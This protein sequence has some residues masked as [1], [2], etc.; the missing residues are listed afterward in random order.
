MKKKTIFSGTATA[1]ITPF[2]YG[3]IDYSALGTIIE[4]QISSKIDALVIGGTTG[5]GAVLSDYERDKLF[6]FCSE[7]TDGRVPLIFGTGSND[8]KRAIKYTKR[9]QNYDANAALIVTPYYNKGTDKGLLLHYQKIANTTDLPIILYNVPSRTGV[10]LPIS[11]VDKL[12]E[13]ENIC[14]IKEASDSADRLTELS[15]L[16]NKITLYSGNDTQIYA[17]LSVGGMGV[18]SVL[19]NAIPCEVLALTNAFWRGDT[20]SALKIQGEL[21]HRAKS[22]FS[23]T[24]PAPIKYVMHLLGYCTPDM[25]LPLYV[26]A[27][28]NKRSLEELFKVQSK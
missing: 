3:K 17:T 14:A 27:E 24:N 19:S 23:E 12:A 22:L 6:S 11:V 7:K 20:D 4:M 2:K 15:L 16:S 28:K 26:P 13:E 1:L 18:I 5:E 21:L 9:A 8:T 25:R 10:N